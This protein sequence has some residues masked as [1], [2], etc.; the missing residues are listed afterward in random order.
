MSPQF[1]SM[2]ELTSYLEAMNNRV[3]TLENQNE[4]LRRSISQ[5][6]EEA[7]KM[8]PE[9]GLLSHSFMKR[10]FTVWG[11]NF[12]IQLIISLVVGIL[13]GSILLI[14]GLF[15]WINNLINGLTLR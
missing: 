5:L 15:P 10:A 13:M 9:T 14:P 3:K 2:N 6:G 8:L 12:V 11:H 1:N 7:P 4:Q